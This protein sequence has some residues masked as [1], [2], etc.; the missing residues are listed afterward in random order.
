MLS[1]MVFAAVTRASWR[2]RANWLNSVD[3]SRVAGAS[4]GHEAAPLLEKICVEQ[5]WSN[6]EQI[7]D[8]DAFGPTY[9]NLP[10]QLDGSSRVW[11][12]NSVARL[13]GHGGA[14]SEG[15]AQQIGYRMPSLAGLGTALH[16]RLWVAATDRE[17]AATVRGASPRA[18]EEFV[19]PGGACQ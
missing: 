17:S 15:V 11:A 6:V 16:F 5:F 7:V 12:L 14:P 4:S 9:G 2:G 1:G 3:W 13:P 10:A 8:S 19:G 18:D